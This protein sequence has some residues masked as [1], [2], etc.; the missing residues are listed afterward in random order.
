VVAL[1]RLPQAP[2]VVFSTAADPVASG[3]VTT[4]AKPGGNI[5]GFTQFEA[6]MGA[7]WL[8]LLKEV[9]PRVKR[10]LVLVSPEN[11]ISPLIVRG[12][13]A[14]APVFG[15]EVQSA[16]ESE[17]DGIERV[18]TAFGRESDRG[19]IVP[20]NAPA[21]VHRSLIVALTAQLSLP[22][23]YSNSGFVHEGGLIGYG[24]D[25]VDEFRRAA[26]YVDRIL[27]G[28]KPADLPVQTPIKFFMSVNL[29]TAGQLGMAIPP[30]VLVRA[31]EVIE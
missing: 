7:K 16:G 11:T 25:N 27:R 22:A 26:G 28:E 15:V 3:F 5:T 14:A 31:D 30:S 12:I 29:K 13:T 4:L 8:E 20:P 19:L 1:R 2:P 21:N 23:V 9:A 17:A 18:L 10:V 6:D 24:V